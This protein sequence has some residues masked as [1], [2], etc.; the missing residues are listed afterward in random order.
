MLGKILLGCIVVLGACN[1][2][3]G[4][5]SL[6]SAM[7][8]SSAKTGSGGFSADLA[9]EMGVGKGSAKPDDKVAMTGSAGSAAKPMAADPKAVDPKAADPKAVDPKATDAKAADPKAVDPKATDPKAADPKAVDPKAT[10]VDP[11][12]AGTKPA[13]PK[14]ID[15]KAADPKAAGTKPADPKAVD[16]KAADP[17][18]AGTKPA[19]IKP[20]QTPVVEPTPAA[21]VKPPANL[22]AIKLS[23]LPNWDR[24]LGEA[25]TF[26][27]VVRIKNTPGATKTFTF[28]Y[29][30]DDPR[31]PS[32]REQYK[33]FL[34]DQKIMSG[35]LRDRQRGGA[36]FIEGADENGSPAFR[37]VVL[38]GG[39]RLVC[40]GSLYK[41]AESNKLG[42]D[43]DQTIIQAKQIC[44]TLA[45]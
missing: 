33:K 28:H 12:A 9:K 39:K 26:Q 19:D 3:E 30:Y 45:L 17:K 22:A 1:K 31:A 43:R 2:S 44:E 8:T 20:A 21:P 37:Y 5:D 11:K 35:D 36:W 34:I 25:G 41:D 16:P 13:D 10:A 7:A 6:G 29:G 14:S 15:P 4:G 42:D 38:Y 32:D 27:Y 24:D 23:L 18:A 40:Y